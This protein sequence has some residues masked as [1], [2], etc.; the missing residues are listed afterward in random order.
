M[1]EARAGQAGQRR[2]KLMRIRDGWLGRQLRR[3]VRSDDGAAALEFALVLPPLC[4]ILVGM[5]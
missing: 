2:V 1:A 5:F 3:F 4:I